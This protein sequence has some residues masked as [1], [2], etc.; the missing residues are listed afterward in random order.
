MYS[1]LK[2][3]LLH[4]MKQILFCFLIRNCI[5]KLH[6]ANSYYLSIVTNIYHTTFLSHDM[7]NFNKNYHFITFYI[8]IDKLK[9]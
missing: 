5:E 6:I 8:I 9:E 1:N 2:N 7:K 4:Y 3:T